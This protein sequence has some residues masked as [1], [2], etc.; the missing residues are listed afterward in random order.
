MHLN[1]LASGASETS[2]L[3]GDIAQSIILTRF[4]QAHNLS[5]AKI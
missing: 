1:A 5:I 3:Y 4:L 2:P